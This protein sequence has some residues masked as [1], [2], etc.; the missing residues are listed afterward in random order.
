MAR[1]TKNRAK[2]KPNRKRS[3]GRKSRGSSKKDHNW[4]IRVLGA[5]LLAIVFFLG[6][7]VLKKP[8]CNQLYLVSTKG[9]HKGDYSEELI[10][11]AVNEYF[12]LRDNPNNLKRLFDDL[13]NPVVW[14]NKT[15][16]L[17]PEGFPKS[18]EYDRFR[19]LGRPDLKDFNEKQNDYEMEFDAAY[20]YRYPEEDF[21][22]FE[23]GTVLIENGEIYSLTT[24]S[25]PNNYHLQWLE[26]V[27]THYWAAKILLSIGLSMIIIFVPG[28]KALFLQI[29]ERI[30]PR[31]LW[32]K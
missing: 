15:Q 5:V 25:R 10:Y 31:A 2:N 16:W 12:G 9:P 17:D 7:T 6:L 29:A 11:E 21:L 1:K 4:K 18:T 14:Y 27:W 8:I 13:T 24:S 32:S 23:S 26:W 19:F 30:L 20:R 22:K 28:V 3:V